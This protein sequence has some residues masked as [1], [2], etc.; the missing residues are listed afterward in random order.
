MYI[1]M[2]IRMYI[3]IYILL[4]LFICVSPFCQGGPPPTPASPP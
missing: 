3:Y 4:V 1:R 2:Y